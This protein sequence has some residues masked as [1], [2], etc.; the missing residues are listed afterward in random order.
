MTSIDR[1]PRARKICGYKPY[2]TV[3]ASTKIILISILQGIYWDLAA[4]SHH[5]K[6]ILKWRIKE[7]GQKLQ[8]VK[9]R[10]GYRR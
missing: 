10:R 5:D 1:W 8:R 7:K 3:L 9:R 4:V 2:L 6:C